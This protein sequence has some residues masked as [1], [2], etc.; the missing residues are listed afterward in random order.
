M[1]VPVSTLTW[2]SSMIDG[3]QVEGARGRWVFDAATPVELR[4]VAGT[5]EF[6][7]GLIPGDGTTQVRAAMVN[8][9]ETAIGQ[10]HDV[11]APVGNMGDRIG[12]EIIYLAGGDQRTEFAFSQARLQVGNEHTA[13]FERSQTRRRRPRRF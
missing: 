2:P 9:Q 1:T 12:R 3:E 7:R 10:A 8:G 6:L 4:V 11:E 5:D 13:D